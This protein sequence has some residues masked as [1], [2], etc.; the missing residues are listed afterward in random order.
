MVAVVV[1][2]GIFVVGLSAVGVVAASLN[3]VTTAVDGLH[4]IEPLETY[5]GRPVAATQ[6]N[7]PANYAMLVADGDR[8][9][10]ALVLH[11]SASRNDLTVVAVPPNVSQTTQGVTLTLSEEY[12]DGTAAVARALET[13]THVRID[14][15]VVLDEDDCW[16]VVSATDGLALSDKSTPK[17][18]T[19]LRA[20][21]G[22][23]AD[24]TQQIVRLSQVIIAAMSNFSML[25]SLTEPGEFDQAI[26]ALPRCLSVDPSLTSDEVAST[27]ISAK[28]HPD[29]IG[30]LVVP[31]A[32]ASSVTLEEIRDALANDTIAA[33]AKKHPAATTP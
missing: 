7:A 29:E 6:K 12:L 21:V 4:R 8:L 23:T 9:A 14:H 1:I 13:L 3:R 30:L 11:L 20:W 15:Q 25:S 24:P 22:A 26:D 5:S 10:G 28:V 33:L 2:V 17:S 18:E 19:Q 27:L 31:S 16:S 32:H